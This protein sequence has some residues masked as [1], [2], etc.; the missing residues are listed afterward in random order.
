[1]N[2]QTVFLG[3][4]L[5]EHFQVKKYF[6]EHNIC[7]EGISGDN[8]DGVLNRLNKSVF[9]FK[10][11]KLFLLIGTNDMCNG[12][13]NQSII[14]GIQN[15][16]HNIHAF[17]SN[18]KIYLQSLYPI[19]SKPD[20]KINEIYIV[21]RDNQ[22]IQAINE[23]LQQIKNIT[24]IDVYHSICDKNLDLMIEYTTEGLHINET[25]YQVISKVLAAYL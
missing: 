19:H 23:A 5:V 13:S 16:I 3:D 12:K 2:R 4:S 20:A 15:I 21:C 17:D 18:I 9:Q 24:Y 10:P 1:M 7:N 6:P 22:R 14:D 25:G 8:I 11:D